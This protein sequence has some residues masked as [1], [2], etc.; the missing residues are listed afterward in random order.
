[1]QPHR[2]RQPGQAGTDDHHGTSHQTPTFRNGPPDG[3]FD[4]TVLLPILWPL[5]RSPPVVPCGP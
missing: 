4:L 5:T 1:M 2:T 3:R